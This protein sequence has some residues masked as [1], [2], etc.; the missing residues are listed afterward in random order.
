MSRGWARTRAGTRCHSCAHTLRESG[1]QWHAPA[2]KGPPGGGG[3]RTWLRARRGVPDGDGQRA[4]EGVD[5]HD[6]RVRVAGRQG[7]ERRRRAGGA[8][9]SLSHVRRALQEE[10]LRRQEPARPGQQRAP[11]GGQPRAPR[12]EAGGGAIPGC[13]WA[14]R[15]GPPPSRPPASATLPGG[16]GRR[17]RTEG[18]PR[19]GVAV[20]QGA[21]SYLFPPHPPPATGHRLPRL[22][23][24][25]TLGSLSGSPGCLGMT[26][27]SLWNP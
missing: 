25:S 9:Q 2:G 4:A 22:A 21:R 6:G 19:A 8:V 13:R 20:V 26:F 27:C 14:L 10:L 18:R 16:Q 3:G 11:G 12:G 15:T 1:R 17:Q 24:L 5:A 7:S 23:L